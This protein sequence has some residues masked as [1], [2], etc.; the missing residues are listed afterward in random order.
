MIYKCKILCH[1]NVNWYLGRGNTFVLLTLSSFF[2]ISKL[3][4]CE[5]RFQTNLVDFSA[6]SCIKG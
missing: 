4:H 3:S 2:K 5:L 1:E 6:M